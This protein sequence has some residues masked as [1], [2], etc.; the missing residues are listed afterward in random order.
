MDLSLLLNHPLYLLTM[1]LYLAAACLYALLWRS[2]GAKLA[3]A[4]TATLSAA[5]CAN[6]ALIAMRWIE[7]GRPPFKSMFESLLVLAFCFAATYLFLEL[8]WRTRHFG[9]VAALGSFGSLL[10]AIGKW[11]AEIVQLPPA[12]Q[13]GWFVPHVVVYFFAYA[14]LFFATVVSAVQLVRPKLTLKVGQLLTGELRLEEV[15]YRSIRFGFLLMT[16][17][18]LVG[19]IW[20]K[21]AWGDYWVWD[22]KENWALV[23][24]LIYAAW[25][26]LH[27]TQ[28]FRGRRAAWLALAGFGIVLFTYLGMGLLPTAET[29]EHVYTN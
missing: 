22:P 9:A 29:S 18:L 3:V 21:E 8:L 17:G 7:A 6:T 23:T 19:S 4:A 25:L 11:D 27:H 16:F 24:W 1:A 13:S 12:L 20:A 10:F 26:H 2:R 14:A 5:L 15:A 28:G